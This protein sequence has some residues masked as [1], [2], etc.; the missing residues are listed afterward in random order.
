MARLKSEAARLGSHAFSV[1]TKLAYAS[2]WSDFEEWCSDT[3]RKALPANAQ[4]LEWFI[5]DR[6][7]THALS[8]IDRRMAA[9]VAAHEMAGF[10]SPYTRSVKEVMRGARRERGSA[11]KRMAALSVKDLRV[12]CRAL[13]ASKDRNASRDRALMTLGF[14]AALRVSE[15]VGLDLADIQFVR[16]GMVVTVRRGKT[17]QEGKGRVAGVFFGER[18]YCC[19]VKSLKLWLRWRGKQPG[20][21]FAGDGVSGRLTPEGVRGIVRRLVVLAGLDPK[22]YGSHS[23]RAGFVTAAAE[24]HVP[25]TLIMQRTGHR[26]VETVAKYVR[27]VSIFQTDALARAL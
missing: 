1:N 17:D 5:V 10:E 3:G 11:Q 26:S 21:V 19:P 13:P 27:P 20:P 7:R 25:E 16:Q 9:I 6:L 2:D 15:L 14:A 24:N 12:I 18:A 23:L 8:S 4:T 22:L